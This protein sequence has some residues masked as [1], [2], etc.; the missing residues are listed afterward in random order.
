MSIGAGR[1]SLALVVN[2]NDAAQDRSSNVAA[3]GFNELFIGADHG[4]NHLL[5]EPV[6]VNGR[7]AALVTPNDVRIQLRSCEGLSSPRGA[8]AHSSS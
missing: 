6:I 7:L 8:R 3:T 5:K 1:R 4:G 2:R